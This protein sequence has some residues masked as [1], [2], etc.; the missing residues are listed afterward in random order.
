[1]SMINQEGG[2]VV[3]PRQDPNE[4]WSLIEKH[5]IEGDE[6]RWRN[7]AAWVLREQAGWPYERIGQ[8]LGHDRGHVYR[9]VGQVQDEMR[10]TF[11][12]PADWPVQSP[13]KEERP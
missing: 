9:I 7:L 5:Y 13:D 3:L 2:K 12:Q 8:A 6:T 4:F 10:K 11:R 1:M